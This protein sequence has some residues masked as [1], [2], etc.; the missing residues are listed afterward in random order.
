MHTNTSQRQRERDFLAAVEAVIPIAERAGI[1]ICLENPGDGSDNIVDSGRAG[2]DLVERIGSPC[3]RL[4]YDFSNI[5][6]YSRGALRPEQDYVDA[7]PV[8]AHLHLKEIARDGFGWR[9]VPIGAGVTH[10]DTILRRLGS[11]APPLAIELPLRHHRGP[12]WR[13][14]LDPREPPVALPAIRAAMTQSLRFV[15]EHL[16]ADRAGDAAGRRRDRAGTRP[17]R[18]IT[19]LARTSS[20]GAERSIEEEAWR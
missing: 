5:Y 18:R 12:D 1:T 2:A 7:L 3:V 6:S 13:I 19:Y 10:Y 16:G 17:P 20:V 8:A 4:N 15:A 11:E 9:F 14:A